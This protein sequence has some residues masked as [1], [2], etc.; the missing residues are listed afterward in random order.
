MR[1]GNSGV[2]S[3]RLNTAI[4]GACI[5]FI[6][7]LLA[8]LIIELDSA[9]ASDEITV[10]APSAK[11]VRVCCCVGI[12]KRINRPRPLPSCRCQPRPHLLRLCSR[13]H[14]V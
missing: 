11:G 14:Y 2:A 7:N 4:A 9:V 10:A 6:T 12:C 3:A 1:A 8:A 5:L 13:P